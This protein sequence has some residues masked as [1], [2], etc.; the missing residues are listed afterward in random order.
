MLSAVHDRSDA[1]CAP[2]RCGSIEALEPR[3][4]LAF[5]PSAL[6]RRSSAAAPP[7]DVVTTVKVGKAPRRSGVALSRSAPF[8]HP[9]IG[10][11]VAD[12]DAIKANLNKQPWKSGYDALVADSRSQLSY[13]MQGPFAQVA[14][15][16][17]GQG[18]NINLTQWRN[19]MQAVYNLSRMWYFTGNGA[20]AQKARDILIAWANTQTSF[21]GYESNLDLGDYAYRFAGGADILRGTWPG[22][23][24]ADTDS[25]K[26]LFENVYW[27]ATGAAGDAPGPANKGALTE[28]S[29]AA[30][31]VFLDDQAKLD[32]VLHLYRTSAASGLQNTLPSGEI[33]ESGRDTGH[34]Y[35]QYLSY[36][37]L[38]EI[39]W[40]QG[41]DVFSDLDNRLLAI[42]EYDARNNLALSTP[43]T[44]MGTTD[45]YYWSLAQGPWA[46]NRMGPN[47]LI[48]HF[49]N[50]EGLSA[51]YMER[52]REFQ[53]VDMDSFMFQMTADASTATPPAPES[54]PAERYATAGLTNLDVGTATPAGSGSY[55]NG[56]WTVSGSGSEIWTH[57]ADSFHFVYLPVTGDATIIAKVNSVQSTHP[58]AKAG[59]MIR[60][61]LSP[62]AAN[63]A[64][65]AIT[66]SQTAEYYMHGWTEIRGGSNWEK[67]SRNVPQTSYWVKLQRI[68]N[69]IG[70]YVS[71]DGTSWAG[72]GEGK[73]GNMGA[74]AYIG[75]AV[76]SLA[77]GT[78]NTSTFSNVR[79]T[80]GVGQAAATV[81][82]APF[83]VYASP[84]D[85]KV[86]LR[87]NGSA[88]ATSYNVKR[89]TSPGGPYTTVANVTD[90]SYVDPNV[91][92][93]TTYYYIVTGVS[94]AGESANSI[95]DVVTPDVTM[96]NVATGGTTSATSNIG[97]GNEGSD[98]AFDRNTGSKW[99]NGNSGTSGWIRYDLGAGK[100]QVVTAYDV[101]T[102]N[103]VPGR[104][105]KNWQFQGSNDATNW[106]T[107]DTRTNQDFLGY[108]YFAKR[109]MFANSTPFRF[110]RL[111]VT[112]NNGDAI[113]IQ[114]SEL[115]LLVAPTAPVQQ[116]K[117]SPASIASG[118]PQ[119]LSFHFG[120]DLRAR[121]SSSSLVLTNT[122]TGTTVPAANIVLGGYDDATDTATYTFA[123]LPDG[124]ALPSG[125][126]SATFAPGLVDTSY[127]YR[128]V[129][130]H[131]TGAGNTVTARLD[132]T[133]STLQVWADAS[134]S[135]PPSYTAA[136]STLGAFAIDGFG[137][138]D[139]LVL[140]ATN[141]DVRPSGA[142]NFVY[143]LGG[144]AETLKVVGPMSLTFATDPAADVEQPSLALE[145]ASGAAA[146]FTAPGVSHLRS[147]ALGTG[148]SATLAPG[149]SKLL[150]LE[151][152]VLDNS[153]TLN[154]TDNDLRVGAGTSRALIEQWIAHARNLGPGGAGAWDG[155]GITSATARANAARNTALGVLAGE[156]YSSVGGNG[157]FDGEAYATADTLVK[158]TYNGDANFSGS[159][160]FDD[161]VRIDVGFNQQRTGWLN[162]D[163]NYSGSVNF[164]DYVL[165]DVTFNSQSGA[166]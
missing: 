108:R 106:T 111:N 20:Y 64:W 161:Y 83:A 15:N 142:G 119:S 28:V 63:R 45:A 29:G 146:T 78:L 8:V 77:N 123:N 125:S 91:S 117:F 87:W 73:F 143:R 110:Y 58:T 140:D 99:F 102:A 151:S 149:G 113:G 54:F 107:L 2:V 42:G 121:L 51:P 41:V 9:G 27:P 59:V 128:F 85:D 137:G 43:F 88:A 93:G 158:Y 100:A 5:G 134:V 31:A 66:P 81:P 160:T 114:L 21:D 136:M 94:A 135:G 39:L 65:V 22:W 98:K 165:I 129:Y 55:S 11:S 159:V 14:R 32:H 56:V 60:D 127:S 62:T 133:G 16:Y 69:V 84:G 163:F 150:S 3:Q 18:I 122:T 162:G 49:V 25:V 112:A 19:D 76:C 96:I 48:N 50:R 131:G 35:G 36:A 155:T 126:Y 154:L 166:L 47:I 105:P 23:T 109:Y 46:G 144:G 40:S 95:E 61:S 80:G 1:G 145:L 68:G 152:V 79:V 153:A 124:N 72:L 71:P 115:S 12:L 24:Q 89:S 17:N 92:N 34:A 44:P 26:A 57:N 38:A 104:D 101:A 164:D 4:L 10:L 90:T 132:A 148:S 70:L 97:S 116:A 67:N 53:P 86:P 118:A 139:T 33:G 7:A 147:L 138:D 130:V 156:E 120:L 157:T 52:R 6:S 75:L 30:I 37:Y 13:T 103:D 74:N 82:A 141:G